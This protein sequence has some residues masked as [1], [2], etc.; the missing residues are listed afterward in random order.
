MMRA[1]VRMAAVI[2]L[3][4]PGMRSAQP[5]PGIAYDEVVRVIVGTSPPPPGSFAD[6]LAAASRATPVPA[7]RR[8]GLAAL[9]GAV[10]GRR[11]SAAETEADRVFAAGAGGFAPLFRAIEGGR[12]EHHAFYNGWERIDDEA[13]QTATIRKCDIDQVITLD[14]RRKTYRVHV[15]AAEPAVLPTRDPGTPGTAAGTAR[16]ITSALPPQTLEGGDARGVDERDEFALNDVSGGCKAGSQ[17][18]ATRTYYSKLAAPHPACP[19]TPER[20]PYPEQPVNIVASAG[21]RPHFTAQK[22]GPLAPVDRLVLYR[23]LEFIPEPPSGATGRGYAFLTERGNIR[24]LGE[25]DASLFSIP[26]GFAAA[27]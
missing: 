25:A 14:L 2:A 16:L 26:A 20:E 1:L 24:F 6:V 27:P 19:I 9:A 12:A 8:G 5:A 10:L 7:P 3:F 17:A 23:S 18:F 13:T 21:C 15:A 11:E 4:L 22:T